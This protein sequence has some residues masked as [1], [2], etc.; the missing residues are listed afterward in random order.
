V[1]GEA[2]S[3]AARLQQAAEPGAIL[4]RRTARSVESMFELE[5]LSRSRSRAR[6]NR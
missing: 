2:V 5:A 4:R 1:T 3:V 6:R